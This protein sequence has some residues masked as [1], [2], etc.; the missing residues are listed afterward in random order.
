MVNSVMVHPVLQAKTAL[1]AACDADAGPS[2]SK[3][4]SLTLYDVFNSILMRS[5]L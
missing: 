5:V 4:L 1:G 3:A 2:A